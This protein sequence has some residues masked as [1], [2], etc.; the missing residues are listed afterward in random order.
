MVYDDQTYN[1]NNN[2][3]IIITFPAQNNSIDNS[4]EVVIIVKIS[5]LHQI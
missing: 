1:K 2:Y 3:N 4:F 5:L